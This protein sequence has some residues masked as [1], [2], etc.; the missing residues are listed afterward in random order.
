MSY[1][2]SIPSR[3]ILCDRTPGSVGSTGMT[4][5]NVFKNGCFLYCLHFTLEDKGVEFFRNVG[6]HSP[7]IKSH[8]KRN[9]SSMTNPVHSS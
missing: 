9:V 8:S 6:N 1:L 5:S 7:T 4:D 2:A 3:S